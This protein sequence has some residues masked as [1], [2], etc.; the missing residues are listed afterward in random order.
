MRKKHA[1]AIYYV[2]CCYFISQSIVAA[3]F[4]ARRPDYDKS[5]LSA[6]AQSQRSLL[7]NQRILPN[8]I[9]KCRDVPAAL[10]LLGSAYP[11]FRVND[12]STPKKNLIDALIDDESHAEAYASAGTEAVVV[13]GKCIAATMEVLRRANRVDLALKLLRLSVIY[14]ARNRNYQSGEQDDG[15]IR[16]IYKTVISLL[17]DNTDDGVNKS[18]LIVHLLRTHMPK[19]ARL[20][21]GVEVFH[22]AISSLGKQGRPDVVLD[23]LSE[24]EGRS[25]QSGSICIDRMSY[26]TAIASLSKH[27]SC[28]EA[29]EVLDRMKRHGFEPNINTYNELL[30]GVAKAAG[31]SDQSSWHQV[32]IA[33]L[34]D[35]IEQGCTPSD[36]AYNSVISCCGKEGAW[37]A[38]AKIQ[39]RA[40]RNL[41]Q[42]PGTVGGRAENQE[43]QTKIFYENL[44]QY[45]K[46]D[47]GKEAWWEIGRYCKADGD[48][49]TIGIQPHRNPLRN[50]LSL[51]FY[52]GST[53]LGRMLLKNDEFKDK[54]SSSLVGMEVTRSRRGEGLSKV[55][56]AIWLSLCL[57]IGAVPQAGIMNKPLISYGL[58]QFGFCPQSGGSKVELLRIREQDQIQG[59][60]DWV[61]LFAI[62]SA[63]P[64]RSLSG[65]YSRRYLRDQNIVVLNHPPS[66]EHKR[67]STTIH[68]KTTFEHPI[69]RDA[70]SLERDAMSD[71]LKSILKERL[72]FL[73]GGSLL[74]RVFVP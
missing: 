55:F 24:L 16:R 20:Q 31:L 3:C 53:K 27:G 73:S 54:T 60:Y 47:F 37:G 15:Q 74:K 41:V 56:L 18:E 4:T 28:H 21:P 43:T 34:D 62:F 30:I 40:S 71:Q 10:D 38:A 64:G 52:D 12:I 36:Q 70:S 46:A 39:A 1:A 2:C 17:G 45:R 33:V 69:A 72:T 65:L 50:G 42:Q 11:H 49:Y 68:L 9:L 7:L 63:N 58:K 51:V 59:N 25:T 67:R 26:Q 5:S 35:M 29:L 57:E 23:L 66:A 61:P 19:Q 44:D 22:A 6:Q 8:K 32:A 14:S 48:T 13:D